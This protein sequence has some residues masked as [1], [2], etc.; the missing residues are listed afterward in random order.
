M[1]FGVTAVELATA[2]SQ[3]NY[4]KRK[5]HTKKLR[6]PYGKRSITVGNARQEDTLTSVD[7]PLLSQR[8]CVKVHDDSVNENNAEGPAG[9]SAMQCSY[10]CLDF[11]PKELSDFE[12]VQES[13]PVT[14]KAQI[15]KW[16]TIPR[17]GTNSLKLSENVLRLRDKLLNLCG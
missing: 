11:K 4:G 15:T 13:T 3:Q 5:Q 16:G 6:G 9:L 1:L 7:I 2:C 14:S 12:T 17:S 10:E 8:K